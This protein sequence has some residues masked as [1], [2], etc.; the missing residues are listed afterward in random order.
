MNKVMKVGA[1]LLAN[2]TLGTTALE[3]SSLL[4][5]TATVEAATSKERATG[6]ERFNGDVNNIPN[7]E[8][9]RAKIKKG[10]PYLDKKQLRIANQYLDAILCP[11]NIYCFNCAFCMKPTQVSQAS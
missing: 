7:I 1:L 9:V 10:K 4:G 2:F 6:K 3:T 5:N 11:K 8:K